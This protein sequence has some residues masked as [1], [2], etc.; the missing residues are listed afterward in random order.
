[1]VAQIAL[2]SWSFK[3]FSSAFRAS[4]QISKLLTSMGCSGF[5]NLLYT[6]KRKLYMT[7]SDFKASISSSSIFS[8][9]SALCMSLGLLIS[10]FLIL[11]LYLEK[12]LLIDCWVFHSPGV[13]ICFPLSP[14]GNFISLDTERGSA[15]VRFFPRLQI[16]QLY[17]P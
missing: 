3:A 13:N 15:L 6:D 7:V 9:Y 4:L 8:S 1:M 5:C 10:C 14:L 11:A 2:I 17:M 16:S 12:K